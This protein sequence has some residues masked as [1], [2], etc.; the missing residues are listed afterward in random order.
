[1]ERL[2]R[3]LALRAIEVGEAAQ[4]GHRVGHVVGA[5]ELLVGQ[6]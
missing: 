3:R 5:P 2:E 6:T 4:G 1:M